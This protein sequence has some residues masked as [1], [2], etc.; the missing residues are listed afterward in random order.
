MNE[1][2]LHFLWKYGLFNREE[3][4]SDSNEAIEIISLGEH[5]YN[6]G[7]DFLNARIKIGN[8]L[9]AGNVE[10]HL[11]SSDWFHHKHHLDSAYNNVILQVVYK[12]D[13]QVYRSNQGIIP[14]VELKFS[15]NLYKK[16]NS[17]LIKHEWKRCHNF[18]NKI[19]PVFI[20]CWLNTLVF[21]RLQQK[22]EII[23]NVLKENKNN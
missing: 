17:L 3:M 2:F 1:D 18:I 13:R 8:T 16:Y 19:D 7:P 4:I 23:L 14:T 22:S 15:E 12:N 6:S 9:W 11:K 5:N 21:E 20:E 10:I